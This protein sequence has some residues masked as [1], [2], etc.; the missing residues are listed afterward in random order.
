MPEAQIKNI[1][2]C[3]QN[4]I[5]DT[6][7]IQ[8]TTTAS[9]KSIRMNQPD[10]SGHSIDVMSV[11]GLRSPEFIGTIALGFPKN[12]FLIVLEKMLG[13]KYETITPEIADA[14]SELLNIIFSSAR[15]NINESGF[16]FEPSIPSTVSGTSLTL[17]HS[18]LVGNSLFFDCISDAGP[19]VSI[20]SLKKI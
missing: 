9:V 5:I 10:M 12:T 3:I 2:P 20:L 7:R 15:K 6:F 17:A 14:C 4:A 11:L 8:L 16:N 19:F 1:P 13:E 18:N